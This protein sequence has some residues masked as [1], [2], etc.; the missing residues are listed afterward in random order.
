MGGSAF[1]SGPT[2]PLTPRMSPETYRWMRDQCHVTLRELF[3]YVATPI[4]GPAKKDHGDIDILVAGE[5]HRFFPRT[6]ENTA[7]TPTKD[8]MAAIK[9]ALHAEHAITAPGSRSANLA[10]PWPAHIEEVH[11][12][13]SNSSSEQGSTETDENQ[14]A[15]RK[16]CVQVDVRI[17]EDIDQLCWVR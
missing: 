13:H 17:C 5:R 2:A 8:L 16:L 3:V 14:T 10:I 6:P 1:G 9:E 11:T 7:P 15:T 4:E 12:Q